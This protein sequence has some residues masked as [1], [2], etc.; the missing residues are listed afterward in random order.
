VCIISSLTDYHDIKYF[1]WNLNVSTTAKFATVNTERRHIEFL[2]VF[3]ICVYKISHIL[4][5]VKWDFL[6]VNYNIS[7][8]PKHEILL[9][10]TYQHICNISKS[11]CIFYYSGLLI[12]TQCK[13]WDFKM[14]NQE[15][16]NVFWNIPLSSSH[17]VNHRYNSNDTF[18]FG[19]SIG[20]FE[21]CE[22]CFW[23]NNFWGDACICLL[24]SFCFP[25]SKWSVLLTKSAFSPSR[26]MSF[27]RQL[28]VRRQNIHTILKL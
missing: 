12:F 18:T 27:F 17:S 14:I 23:C 28:A 10:I 2:G 1:K 8:F 24:N 22:Q 19:N 9:Y 13:T 15:I 3:T 5:T 6:W 21:W 26:C 16:T 25:W 20:K 7:G 11:T 4:I